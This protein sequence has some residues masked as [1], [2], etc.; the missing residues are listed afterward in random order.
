MNFACPLDPSAHIPDDRL[1]ELIAK[2]RLKDPDHY[3]DD[4]DEDDD[5]LE[6]DSDLKSSGDGHDDDDGDEHIKHGTLV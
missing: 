2:N 6:G 3:D 1:E 4:D 5:D